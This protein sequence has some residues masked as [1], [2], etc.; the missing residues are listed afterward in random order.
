LVIEEFYIDK[1]GDFYNTE[2][3]YEVYLTKRTYGQ[4][5]GRNCWTYDQRG[6]VSSFSHYSFMMQPDSLP[7]FRKE[8]HWQS[9]SSLPDPIRIISEIH[10]YPNPCNNQVFLDLKDI[11]PDPIAVAIYDYSGKLVMDYNTRYNTGTLEIPV[12]D[13]MPGSYY[14]RI[15]A[16]DKILSARFVKY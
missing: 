16:G 14:I 9:V 11:L 1:Q 2:T 6:L 8:F 15:T 13:L 5:K 3:G 10:V 7:D 12:A 4:L